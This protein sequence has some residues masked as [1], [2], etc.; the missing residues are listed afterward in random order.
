[1]DVFISWSGPR[2]KAV[3]SALRDWLP[4]VI[5]SL[6]PWMSAEDIEKG[7]RWSNDIAKRLEDCKVGLVC[8][9]LENLNAPWILFETGALS[10]TLQDTYVIPV[11]F[12]FSPTQLEGPLTQFQAVKAEQ[13]DIKS[14][15]QTI[16]RASGESALPD[17]FLDDSFN[18]WWPELEQALRDVPKA[19]VER[20]PARP[21]RELLEEVLA[22]VRGLSRQF[23]SQESNS[24]AFP[25][26]PAGTF[27]STVGVGRWRSNRAGLR[28]IREAVEALEIMR[29]AHRESMSEDPSEENDGTNDIPQS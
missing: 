6:N 4:K 3:A 8:L 15:M 22:E 14:L 9:T 20:A 21:D 12:Q 19:I 7:S 2:S 5:Q 17:N 1:M 16:N 10:K 29:R 26:S 25:P 23:S 28:A 18:K 13:E 27:T 24:G 11:L